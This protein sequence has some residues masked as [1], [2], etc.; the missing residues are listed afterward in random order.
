ME[1]TLFEEA[2]EAYKSFGIE[3]QSR[4]EKAAKQ[5][6]IRWAK[7]EIVKAAHLG[8]KN[9][10]LEI[11]GKDFEY[12]EFLIRWFSENDLTA[13]ERSDGVITKLF[14]SGWVK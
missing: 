13:C 9:A 14:V 12:I 4:R 10:T 6:L 3:E 8:Y 7:E 5:R 11:R 2:S 1:K